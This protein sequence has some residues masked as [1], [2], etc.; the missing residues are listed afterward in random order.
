[1]LFDMLIG[2]SNSHLSPP[3]F[4]IWGSLVSFGS[5]IQHPSSK[6]SR[7]IIEEGGERMLSVRMVSNYK[8]STGHSRVA[9][10]I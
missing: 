9:P 6:G 4:G 7:V 3:P 5:D 2:T 10:H 1:M 8:V